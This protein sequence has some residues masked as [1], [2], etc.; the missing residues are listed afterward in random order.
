MIFAEEHWAKREG[1]RHKVTHKR[2]FPFYSEPPEIPKP[3][4]AKTAPIIFSVPAVPEE[5]VL[6]KVKKLKIIK[7][8]L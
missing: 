1:K 4:M 8:I 6:E 5:G 7:N 3:K 2:K